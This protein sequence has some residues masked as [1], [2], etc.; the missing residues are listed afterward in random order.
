MLLF[1]QSDW[2]TDIIDNSFAP[3][4]TPCWVD[5]NCHQLIFDS[6]LMVFKHHVTRNYS[7]SSLCNGRG[8]AN[9]KDKK[10]VEL[11]A[12]F[13]SIVGDSL[14]SYYRFNT[15]LSLNFM[16][17]FLHYDQIHYYWLIFWI[18]RLLKLEYIVDN[19]AIISETEIPATVL[20]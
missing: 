19:D 14:D 15:D 10:W 18:R 1:F 12:I 13:I 3:R 7:L 20:V 16:P 11:Y 5:L 17:L 9:Y 8:V 6:G 4:K 2:V